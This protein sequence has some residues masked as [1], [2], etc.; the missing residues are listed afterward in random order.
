MCSYSIQLNFAIGLFNL[1]P[2]PPLDGSKMI[3]SVL[4]YELTRKYEAFAR[5]GYWLLWGLLIFGAFNIL[6]TPILWL[7]NST[8][9]MVIFIFQLGGASI[10]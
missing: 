7:S 6:Y 3:E 2:I 9:G 1:V 8:L 4:S 10:S 5:Y